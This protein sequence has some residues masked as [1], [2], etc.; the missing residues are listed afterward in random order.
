MNSE[1]VKNRSIIEEIDFDIR[2]S[3]ADEGVFEEI[4]EAVKAALG[5]FDFE[6]GYQVSVSLVDEEE[7]RQLNSEYRSVD[8]VTDVL[9]FPLEETDPRGVNLLGDVVI[10]VNMA[11]RQAQEYGHSFKRELGYLTVHSILHLM[12]YDHENEG[13]KKLMR[14]AEDKIMAQMELFRNEEE[15]KENEIKT[16]L[17]QR[18][19]DMLKF[20]YSPY[21]NFKV[22]AAILT[23]DG[24]VFT[25]C[26]IENASYGATICAER[27][28]AVKAVSEGQRVFKAIAI[29]CSGKEFA[30]P[31]GICRQFLN[32]FM[33]S[34]APVILINSDNMIL[35]EVFGE[36]L[37]H[38]FKGKDML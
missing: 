28:A 21:S 38:G 32:E 16:L 2:T 27:T 15:K 8:S 18:A 19:A 3:D 9:S 30:Y 7:I 13:D 4:T 6:K 11:R 17:A 29:A 33:D 37:P 22:G 24:S 10:C 31:C 5:L 34:E 12:G 1:T 26:N 35:T 14:S 20:S 36:L 23:E 25:G